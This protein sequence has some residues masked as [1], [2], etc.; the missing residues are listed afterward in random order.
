MKVNH[1]EIEKLVYNYKT[2]YPEGFLPEE[3]N[4][5]IKMYPNINMD[6]YDDAMMG[7][8]CVMREGKFCMYHCDVYQALMCGLENRDL[9]VDEW[10]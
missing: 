4:E 9:M 7:N 1:K 5:L 6:K 8:T 2:K 3:Q 10:D